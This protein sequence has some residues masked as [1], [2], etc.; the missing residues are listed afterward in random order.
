MLLEF[1]AALLAAPSLSWPRQTTQNVQVDARV[2]DQHGRLVANVEFADRW[3]C[4]DGRWHGSMSCAEPSRRQPL[5][6]DSQ[7]R[8]RGLWI[9]DPFGTPLL[10]YSPDRQL[11]AFAFSKRD[12][13]TCQATLRGDVVLVPA[14]SV[15]GRMRTTEELPRGELDVSLLVRHPDWPAASELV[16]LRVNAPDFCLPLPAG[17]YQVRLSYGFGVAPWRTFLVPAGRAEFDLGPVTVPPKPFDL[18]GEVLPD[19]DVASP[20]GRKADQPDWTRFRGKPLLLVF[21]ESGG[22]PNAGPRCRPALAALASHPRRAEFAVA[23]CDTA[24]RTTEQIAADASKA[25]VAEPLFTVL[26]P[27]PWKDAHELY[28]SR[29]AIVVLDAEGRL[30]HCGQAASDAVVALERLLR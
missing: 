21:D 24:L 15:V 22:T 1:T 14:V 2:V 6:C 13:T 18:I 16:P 5:L 28:G 25:P 26:R 7:G 4:T 10:G 3:A 29:W 19:W 30:A 20:E 8:L 17:T 27:E 12:P 9:E 11:V 23:V